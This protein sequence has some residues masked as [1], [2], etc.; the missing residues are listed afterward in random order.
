MRLAK[1]IIAGRKFGKIKTK[2]GDS[3]TLVHFNAKGDL[4]LVGLV[5][6]GKNELAKQWTP[7]GKRNKGGAPSVFDL[8]I[9]TEGG[10]A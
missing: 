8:V 2:H 9:E 6:L 7:E 10:E 3:V 1:E 5:D 4:P